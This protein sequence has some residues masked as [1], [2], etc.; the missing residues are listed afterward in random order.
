MKNVEFYLEKNIKEA[1]TQLVIISTN[2]KKKVT[3]QQ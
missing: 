2:I 1:K 3:S